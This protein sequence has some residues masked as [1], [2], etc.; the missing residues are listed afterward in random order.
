[1]QLCRT[2]IDPNAPQKMHMAL[3]DFVY[4][5]GLAFGIASDAKMLKINEV[6]RT[7]H[8]D[9]T[10]PNCHLV[11]DHLL[12]CLSETNWEKA[13]T[14]LLSEPPLFSIT[15]SGDDVTILNSPLV[16]VLGSGVNN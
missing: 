9:Y 15:M 5:H 6:A 2:G 12:I 4:S 16:N 13:M 1:M 14:S 3:D 7:L 10:P 8:D 11:G